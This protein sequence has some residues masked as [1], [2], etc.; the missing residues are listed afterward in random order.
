M[1]QELRYKH[2]T[3]SLNGTLC[4]SCLTNKKSDVNFDGLYPDE[5]DTIPP[6]KRVY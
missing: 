5:M 4:F 6:A 2:L 3:K 1:I